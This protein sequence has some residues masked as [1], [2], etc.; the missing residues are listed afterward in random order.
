VIILSLLFSHGRIDDRPSV[1][2]WL[3][4]YLAAARR[5]DLRPTESLRSGLLATK[6]N[7]GSMWCRAFV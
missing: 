2:Q 7:E 5:C 4:S 6:S 3:P 1:G